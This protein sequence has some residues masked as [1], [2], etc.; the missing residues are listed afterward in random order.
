[1]SN[2]AITAINENVDGIN[3]KHGQWNH[4]NVT[5][6]KKIKRKDLT[7]EEKIEIANYLLLNISALKCKLPMV[8]KISGW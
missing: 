1:M 4:E 5:K 3:T 2:F 7:E 8:I 6:I